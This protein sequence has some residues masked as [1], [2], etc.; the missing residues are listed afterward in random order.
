MYQLYNNNGFSIQDLANSGMNPA[1][2]FAFS[3]YAMQAGYSYPQKID[4]HTAF[5][6]ITS[7]SDIKWFIKNKFIKEI[8]NDNEKK[9]VQ[10]YRDGQKTIAERRIS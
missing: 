4:A 5:Q 1:D 2:L 7:C 6:L 3:F 10:V 8:E 9:P